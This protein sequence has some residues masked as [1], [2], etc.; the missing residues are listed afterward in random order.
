LISVGGVAYLGF[1]YEIKNV[2]VLTTVSRGA[3]AAPVAGVGSAVPE[4][5]GG[6][7]GAALTCS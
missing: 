4:N 7:G 2:L 3:A 6:E 1:I 5:P